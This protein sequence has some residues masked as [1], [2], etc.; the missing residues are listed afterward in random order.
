MKKFLLRTDVELLV[1]VR[2][3][4]TLLV[5]QRT[6]FRALAS[7]LTSWADGIPMSDVEVVAD[8]FQVLHVG[9]QPIATLEDYDAAVHLA[10]QKQLDRPRALKPCGPPTIVEDRR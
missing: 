4:A 2:V 1:P 6:G 5:E 7:M 8:S 10:V 3:Q 9:S